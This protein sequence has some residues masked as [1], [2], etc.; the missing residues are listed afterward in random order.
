M[1]R[2]GS[3]ALAV[4]TRRSSLTKKERDKLKQQEEDEGMLDIMFNLPEEGQGSRYMITKDFVEGRK[5]KFPIIEP[6]NKSA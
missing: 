6:K 4:P 1:R 2:V 5:P 3:P